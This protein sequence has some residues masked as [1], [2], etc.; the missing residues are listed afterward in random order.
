MARIRGKVVVMALAICGALQAQAQAPAP[1][2]E[3]RKFLKYDQPLIALTHVRVIDGTGGPAQEERT[4]IL[5]NGRIEAV[6]DARV[7]PPAGAHVVA[8]EGH[9][10]MPGLVGMHNHLMYTASLHQDEEGHLPPP[11]FLVTELAFS[12]P[13][14]YLAAGVT[15]MRTTGS[16][17]P[18]T[19]LNIR[20]KIDALEMPGPHI[21]VT[22]PYLEGRGSVF[23]QM[24]SLEEADHARR[25]VAFW[26]GEGATSFKAYMN[27]PQAVLAAAID[28]AHKHGRKLTGHLCSVDYR[29]AA[30]LGIDNLEHGPVFTDSEFVPGRKQDQCPSS[31]AIAASWEKLEVSSPQVQELIRDL[32]A[33]KVALTS[34][35]PVFESFVATRPL[36]SR[37]QQSM[38][39]AESLRSHLAARAAAAGAPER[40]AKL[41]AALKKEMAFELAFVRA[42]GLLLAGPDPTGNGGVLPGFGDQRELQLLVEAGFTPVEAIRIGTANGARFLSRLDRI[43]TIEAGKEADL[44]VVKGDP[45][46]RIADVENVQVVFKDGYGYDPAKLVASVRGMVGVR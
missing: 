17:E 44:V 3:V 20:N 28:E 38:M 21:D 27:I 36:L 11:G 19:D 35:L 5:R 43:G 4:V 18:Y 22:G 32:V 24:T 13:R 14:L 15:T 34:P 9:S 45:S 46:R 26:S 10:V 39:S 29:Q 31:A 12:A 37:Q 8:L 1:S 33:H 30:A 16:I 6:T 25:T 2:A 42:G 7:A 41:E 23:P 40:A